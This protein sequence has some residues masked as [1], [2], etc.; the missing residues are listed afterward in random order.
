[1][2]SKTCL[3]PVLLAALGSLAPAAPTPTSA[4]SVAPTLDTLLPELCK[5]FTPDSLQWLTAL[6]KLA[7]NAARP[8][9]EKERSAFSAALCGKAADT[10]LPVT[11]RWMVLRQ[12]GL[13]GGAE[14]VEPLAALFNDENVQVREYARQAMEL[15]SDPRAT[16]VLLATLAKG[17][18]VRWQTGLIHSLGQRRS[19]AAVKVLESRLQ[20]PDYVGAAIIA[21]KKIATPDAV[22][23]LEF[24]CRWGR[25]VGNCPS[26]ARKG[27][28][29][30]HCQGAC[31]SGGLAFATGACLEAAGKFGPRR[32]AKGSPCTAHRDES[33]SPDNRGLSDD[34]ASRQG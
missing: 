24:I 4:P 33:A 22:R 30:H 23:A 12:V 25:A 2:H 18:D 11:V 8:G 1:M 34:H 10:K 14:A 20:Q 16:T 17:G 32:R 31:R 26:A 9:A 29:G 7:A 5:A 27:E 13:I 19:A 21:L 3:L 6:E 28:R 15:N